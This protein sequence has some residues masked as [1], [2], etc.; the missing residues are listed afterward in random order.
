MK[1]LKGY[2]CGMGIGGWL[3]NYKRFNVLPEAW[4]YPIT[5][6]DMEH[7]ESYITEEDVLN[8]KTMGFDHVRVGFD[9]IV[10]EESPFV[11]RERIF[12]ILETF[13]GWCKK[14]RL[15]V[16][17][18]LHK[19]VGNYCD[20]QEE[21]GL[22][23]NEELQARVVALWEK[24]EDRFSG[25]KSV[26]FE[27]L[28]EVL[29]VEPKLWNAFAEKLIQ[30]IRAKNP[31]RPIIV[32][33]TCWNSPSKL[34]D[35]Q[36]YDDENVFY[37]FHFYAPFE[38]THQR[39]VLQ[40]T[41]MY[42]NRKTYYPSDIEPYKD[43]QRLVYNA[44]EP[45]KQYEKMDKQFLYDALAGAKEF[46]EKYPDKTLWCGEFGTIRHAD[47]T[48]RENWMNDVISI[49]QEYEIPYSVWN[50]LSTPNDGNRFSLVDDDTRQILSDR[51]LRIL[52]GDI[53]DCG[54]GE[55]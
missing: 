39:G 20:I 34:N 44:K 43:Y 4:R 5:V 42:Y 38:F 7:F 48:S 14:Y 41:T 52:L 17:F 25:E 45:Y 15:G 36:V 10:L 54:V 26:F 40:P 9:Q 35:L 51:L 6:G 3:T 46:R 27:L 29:D 16:V 24:L 49:L 12:E 22:M 47:L 1:T 19:A 32:G 37:T 33:T 53:D 31:V 50:Y 8:I 28:N 18:N 30:A 55:R 21:A 11:Y 2:V 23:E 13:V